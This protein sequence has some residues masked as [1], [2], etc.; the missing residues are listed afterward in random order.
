MGSPAE[1]VDPSARPPGAAAADANRTS[2]AAE[3]RLPCPA[4]ICLELKDGGQ[5]GF[6]V[7]DGLGPNE[8]FGIGAG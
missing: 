7:M 5:R 8:G 1:E 6:M 3:A 4:L 2:R